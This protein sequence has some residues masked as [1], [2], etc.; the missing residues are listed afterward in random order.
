MT[1]EPWRATSVQ[2]RSIIGVKAPD[3]AGAWD[4]INANIDHVAGLIDAATLG[5]APPKLVVL[6]EFAM[7]GPPHGMA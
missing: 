2:T 1:I 3:R 5:D 6:P 7:Q 4:I